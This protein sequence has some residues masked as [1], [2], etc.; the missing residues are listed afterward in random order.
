HQGAPALLYQQ[1]DHRESYAR[2]GVLEWATRDSSSNAR[3]FAPGIPISLSHTRTRN[4]RPSEGRS[5]RPLL[6]DRLA[7]GRLFDRAPPLGLFAAP[8]LARLLVVFVGPQLP[9]DPTPLDQ[10]LEPPEGRAD[11]LPVVDP[12]SQSHSVSR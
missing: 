3:R 1:P 6:L 11:R 9:F 10:L 2:P 4:P 12:H 8:G 7:E 5:V